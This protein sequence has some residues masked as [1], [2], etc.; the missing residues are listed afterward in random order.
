M[1]THNAP[2]KRTL[3]A[4]V[5]KLAGFALAVSLAFAANEG[6]GGDSLGKDPPLQGSGGGVFAGGINGVGSGSGGDGNG[7]PCGPDGKTRD[8]GHTVHQQGGYIECAVGSQTCVAGQWGKCVVDKFAPMPAPPP[9]SGY[10]PLSLQMNAGPCTNDPCD[11]AC[12]QYS[13]TGDGFD[14]GPGLTNADGGVELTPG[15][16]K[17][18]GCAMVACGDGVVSLGEQC[19]DGNTTSGDGCSSTCQ[20]EPNFTCP[21]PGSPCTPTPCGDG[22]VQGQETCDDGNAVSGDGC[23]ATCQVEPGWLCPTPGAKC[24]AKQCGDG[25]IAGNEACDDGNTTSGDGCSATCTREK[26]FACTTHSG[27][28]NSVCH[29]TVCGDGVKEG[30]E[31]CDD[32]N[33]KPYDGCSPSCET[34]AKCAGGACTATCGDGLKFPTEACDDGNSRSGDGCSPTC[35]IEPGFSCTAVDE[36][37]PTQLVIPILYRDMHYS[38]TMPA[39]HPD[40]ENYCCGVRTGLVN[41][42]LGPDSEPVFLSRTGSPNSGNFLT[43]KTAFCWWYHDTSTAQS[44]DCGAV[45]TVNPYTKGTGGVLGGPV[46]LDAGGNPMTLTLA[47]Q[48]VG[49]NI[50]KF[51][52]NNFY[53]ID[54]LGWNVSSPQL[55]TGD[56]GLQHNFSFTSELHYPFTYRASAPVATFS[57]DGDDD[58]WAF[59]NGHLIV[60][61][62]GVH[63]TTAA[64]YTLTAANASALGLV[65][66]GMYSIDLFQAERHTT[67]SDYTLTLSGFVHTVSQCSPICGDGLV[68]GSEV[69]DDGVNNGAYGGCEPGC[70]ARAPFCGDGIVQSPQ[71]DCDNGTNAVVYGGLSATACGPGCKYAPYCGDG[72]VSNGEQ[73]DE[74]AM[75]G[76]GGGCRAD[77]TRSYYYSS[78]FTRDFDGSGCPDGTHPVW[79]DAGMKADFPTHAGEYGSIQMDAQVGDTV[80]TLGPVIPIGT[81]T[82]P[83]VDQSSVWTIYDLYTPLDMSDP[84][85]PYKTILRLTFTLDPSADNYVTPDLL[86]WRAR[87]TCAPSE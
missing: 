78:S 15:G 66:N 1:P 60:D 72:V 26:G 64:S 54:G 9:G 63:G 2:H 62:G 59:I 81:M 34:E 77:C 38:G 37:P 21:T 46:Y 45:G 22:H 29:A 70:T 75:N 55:G 14:A 23:S 57:F 87:F 4:W 58:V 83:P 39:G 43:D 65:D 40:F 82:G 19:D 7:G 52:S 28:P 31:Q 67:G 49:T 85:D 11:P 17:G 32:G 53:P 35:T 27:I 12:Q 25:I 36:S 18:G 16:C 41:S 71:E 50:Y 48:G 20:L 44:P 33:L 5:G 79:I 10:S 13:D 47:E 80:A 61:L 42:T 74:G 51:S 6:C 68:K 3:H 86:E 69:C 24:I 76:T 56:D 73:C 8:C 84:S 30:F